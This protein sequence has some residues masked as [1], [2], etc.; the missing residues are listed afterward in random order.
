MLEYWRPKLGKWVRYR[1]V[2]GEEVSNRRRRR[3]LKGVAIIDQAYQLP[4]VSRGVDCAFY[5]G[6]YLSSFPREALHPREVSEVWSL[7][8]RKEGDSFS[9]LSRVVGSRGSCSC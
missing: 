2:R 1:D 6:E 9:L 4:T 7:K 3:R 8:Q 5:L